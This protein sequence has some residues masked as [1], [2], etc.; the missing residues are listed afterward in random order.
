MKQT[1]L[2]N[3][4][5]FYRDGIRNIQNSISTSI[6]RNNRQIV[7]ANLIR[8]NGTNST[9]FELKRFKRTEFI[10]YSIA[11]CSRNQEI[12]LPSIGHSY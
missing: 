5:L 2:N 9:F 12:N 6:H 3:I 1:S 8:E 11:T 7:I 10:F 4:N